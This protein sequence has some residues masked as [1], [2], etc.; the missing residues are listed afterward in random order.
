[1]AQI[2]D[3]AQA[4][5]WL[6]LVRASAIGW[7]PIAQHRLPK[8]VCTKDDSNQDIYEKKAIIN[9]SGQRFEVLTSSLNQYPH[10]LL[11]SDERDYFYD[12]NS[13]EY[14]FDRDPEIFRHILTYY[15]CGHL[16][17]PKKECVMQYEDELAYFRIASEALGDCCYEDYHD[18]KRENSERLLEERSSTKENAEVPK[19]FR[20]RLWQAFEN[21]EFST[22]AIVIYYVTGFFIAVSVFANITETI[23]CGPE[24]GLSKQRA[25]GDRY[26]DAFSCLDTAC[27][28]IFTVEY[29]ARMYAA[30]NRWKFFI[31][32]MS[33]IDVVAILPFYIGLLMP[34]NKSV[35]GVFTTLRVFRVFR[36]FKFSRHSVG[37]RILGYTLKS[38]ASELGFLLFSLTMVIIIFATVMYYAEKSVEGTTF[39]SIPSSFWY[40]IVTMTTLGYGDMV[41]ETIVGKIVGGMCSLS[42]VLVIALPVPVIVSNF[43]RIYNQS[44]RS[45]K[46]Q[47]Q[48]RARQARIRL[49]QLMATVNACAEK[50]GSPEP[51]V[52][53][54]YDCDNETKKSAYFEV[55]TTTS[56]SST[57]PASI[58]NANQ[59]TGK[60]QSYDTSRNSTG[61]DLTISHH[62]NLTRSGSLTLLKNKKKNLVNES[63]VQT[64]YSELDNMNQKFEHNLSTFNQLV[65]GVAKDTSPGSG[66][67]IVKKDKLY[68]TNNS[69]GR[70][71]HNLVKQTHGKVLHSSS[72]KLSNKRK[73]VDRTLSLNDGR[74]SQQRT[75]QRISV[76]D[77]N[78]KPSFLPIYIHPASQSSFSDSSMDKR[79]H[80][81]EQ[82]KHT[83]KSQKN[84][85]CKS[86]HK[87]KLTFE[88]LILLQQKHLMDCLNVV[89]ARATINEQRE[90][91]SHLHVNNPL[92]S[93]LEHGNFKHH[94]RLTSE[95]I[96]KISRLLRVRQSISKDLYE[97]RRSTS[98]LKDCDNTKNNNAGVGCSDHM[99]NVDKITESQSA[100]HR[101]ESNPF[102]HLQVFRLHGSRSQR[103]SD[104][105]CSAIHLT[106]FSKRKLNLHK[107]KHNH[108]YR[109][110][111]KKIN[112][113]TNSETDDNHSNKIIVNMKVVSSSQIPDKAD[114]MDI[115]AHSHNDN[116]TVDNSV[117]PS[118]SETKPLLDNSRLTYSDELGLNDL[119]NE[120]SFL[121]RDPGFAS[122]PTWPSFRFPSNSFQSKSNFNFTDKS[123]NNY[124]KSL[125]P[126]DS[127]SWSNEHNLV[128]T[129]AIPKSSFS[130]AVYPDSVIFCTSFNTKAN[131]SSQSSFVQSNLMCSSLE[132]ENLTEFASAR[133]HISITST[134]HPNSSSNNTTNNFINKII[135]HSQNCP[136]LSFPTDKSLYKSH[137]SYAKL[138]PRLSYSFPHELYRNVSPDLI[139]QCDNQLKNSPSK[140]VKSNTGNLTDI[141]S[142]NAS[143]NSDRPVSL[144]SFKQQK[145]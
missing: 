39:S 80:S 132:D 40:T 84:N 74:Q 67:I 52:D 126:F 124:G 43:S 97:N 121:T 10:T 44:Q 128:N 91:N 20:N 51:S 64:D 65:S 106:T 23:P 7:V 76:E 94:R 59:S 83:T 30:P 77:K 61:S 137:I 144:S 116:S 82:Q 2:C 100:V 92:I 69:S 55:K 135:T 143:V 29:C 56:Y 26:I 141:H 63:C 118:Y 34:D 41:P 95:S 8:N 12:E 21:P 58:I 98:N 60:D 25:C 19:D 73:I 70:N 62:S 78:N 9:V 66:H 112:C 45:D 89:T 122:S 54:D 119:V 108:G 125:N 50:S 139:K 138:S 79:K 131:V 27:V 72:L 90:S 3:M 114:I 36:V 134:S 93:A 111:Y 127:D 81:N 68:E 28:V 129:A 46:R 6:P 17:Y 48:K 38:C 109:N 4:S 107:F 53:E 14:Y 101:R 1:M 49:A 133:S 145:E 105:R 24:P 16:H 15:R 22:T 33:I 35:S 130:A 18:S 140:L 31:S 142:S 86:F 32:V 71:N 47:A 123:S 57:S 75:D 5:A 87:A 136:K 117:Y 96:S 99:S 113:S 115:D 103:A 102:R 42:G 13:G 88:D 85:K 120:K 37:L 110:F 104:R 11:G